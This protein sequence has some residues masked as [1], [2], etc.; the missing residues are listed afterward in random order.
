MSIPISYVLKR[1]EGVCWTKEA[2]KDTQEQLDAMQFS[3]QG[4]YEFA[5]IADLADVKEILDRQIQC[6]TAIAEEG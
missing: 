6:N 5:E 2:R 4:I 1:M 3:M